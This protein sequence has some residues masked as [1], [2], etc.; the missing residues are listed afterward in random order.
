MI[1]ENSKNYIGYFIDLLN[2]LSLICNFTYEISIIKNI[3]NKLL[4]NKSNDENWNKIVNELVFK[5]S[6]ICFN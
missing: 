3:E 5:V 2:K 6:L 1:D 4:I